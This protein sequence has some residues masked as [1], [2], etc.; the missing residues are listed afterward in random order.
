MKD[1]NLSYVDWVELMFL[2]TY[3]K[4][5]LSVNEITRVSRQSRYDTVAYAL[6]KIRQ[7]LMVTNQK[8]PTDYVSELFL[9]EPDS[10]NQSNSIDR[11]NLPKSLFIHISKS[12]KKGND[13]IHFSLNLMDKKAL[14]TKL[15]TGINKLPK[16]FPIVNTES[17]DKIVKLSVMW[18]KKLKENFIKNVKGTYHNISLIYLKGML[19]EYAFKYNYRKENRD[20]LMVFLDLI[21][22][23]LGQNSA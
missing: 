2:S 5:P 11:P 3:G 4:K 12:K 22:K 20:K 14:I 23:S 7:L 8:L 21:A 16:I 19:A 18:E 6:K 9:V 15:E 10:E 1:S 17:T 13:K